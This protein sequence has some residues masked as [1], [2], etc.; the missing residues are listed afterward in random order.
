M[1]GV[2]VFVRVLSPVESF[3]ASVACRTTI[4][5]YA[6]AGKLAIE[7]SAF[8]TARNLMQTRFDAKAGFVERDSQD[9]L[10]RGGAGV[11]PVFSSMSF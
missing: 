11:S 7:P 1:R 4:P 8:S 2:I 5:F 3:L 9:W 6:F 10:S